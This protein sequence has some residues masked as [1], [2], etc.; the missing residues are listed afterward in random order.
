M[1]EQVGLCAA[2]SKPMVCKSGFLEGV[3]LAD[4]T[5]LCFPCAKKNEE[6]ELTHPS[7]HE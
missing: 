4:G 6:Q 7:E 2:C 5:L 3:V 1:E